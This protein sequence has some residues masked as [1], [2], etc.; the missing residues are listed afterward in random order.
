MRVPLKKS[1]M[2]SS[3]RTTVPVQYLSTQ[4]LA[5]TKYLYYSRVPSTGTLQLQPE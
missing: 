2:C 3:V 5:S 1:G 4:V